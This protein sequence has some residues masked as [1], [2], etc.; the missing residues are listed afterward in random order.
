MVTHRQSSWSPDAHPW[1]SIELSG[2]SNTREE[3][4]LLTIAD[5]QETNRKLTLQLLSLAEQ[6]SMLDSQWAHAVTVNTA[7]STDP[8]TWLPDREKL[9]L[10]YPE[11]APHVPRSIAILCIND[12]RHINSTYGKSNGDAMIHDI[13]ATFALYASENRTDR[14]RLYKLEWPNFA[15]VF[16]ESQNESSIRSD[17]MKLQNQVKL[18]STLGIPLFFSIWIAHNEPNIG[19]LLDQGLIDLHRVKIA[20]N[21]GTFDHDT[22]SSS[23]GLLKMQ[24]LVEQAFAQGLFVVHFQ[25]I[26]QNSHQG[27]IKQLLNWFRK[28]V[29][30]NNW[31]QNRY[32]ALVRMMDATN[33]DVLMWPMQ[34]LPMVGMMWKHPDLTTIV[35]DRVCEAWRE[36]PWHYSINLTADDLDTPGHA[37]KIRDQIGRYGIPLSDIGLEIYEGIVYLTPTIIENI[38]TLRTLWF[39]IAI[40]DMWAGF[41]NLSRISQFHAHSIKIDMSLIRGIDT[42]GINRAIV[43]ALI[44]LAHTLKMQVVAEGIETQVEYEVIRELGADYS[45]G[46]LFGRPCAFPKNSISDNL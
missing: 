28:I 1:D 33:T 26:I 29:S 7:T 31:K 30:P 24:A 12:M 21:S 46:Y 35:I 25:P 2:M 40:D 17:C 15:I 27:K 14:V 43:R 8:R 11:D 45:Q 38:N 32:E 42:N 44:E 18:S 20:R 6:N 4:L 41:S 34:F 37:Q 13:E 9:L 10:D 39:K 22:Q 36:H 16:E 23:E 19:T 3:A 5:L